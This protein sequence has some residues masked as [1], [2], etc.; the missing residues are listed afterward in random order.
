MKVAE[1]LS[2]KL[3]L[4]LLSA[5]VCSKLVLETV[6]FGAVVLSRSVFATNVLLDDKSEFDR[7]LTFTGVAKAPKVVFKLQIL[8]DPVV[9]V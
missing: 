3:N 5:I 7:S 6:I 2:L 4:H 1:W 8:N 9:C